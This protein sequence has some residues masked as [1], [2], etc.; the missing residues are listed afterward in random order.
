VASYEGGNPAFA[1]ALAEWQNIWDL[2]LA[3]WGHLDVDGDAPEEGGHADS[4]EVTM[5][6]RE[7]FSK[8]LENVAENAVDADLR[9]AQSSG[10]HIDQVGCHATM[11]KKRV[12]QTYA[13]VVCR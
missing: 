6:R 7:A 11:S 1:A 9:K 8:W 2:C 3:L 5:R 12:D 13:A 4:H 10:N